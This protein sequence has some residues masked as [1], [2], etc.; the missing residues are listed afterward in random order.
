MFVSLLSKMIFLLGLILIGYIL[1]KAKLMPKDSAR[2]ISRLETLILMP[3]LVIGTLMK[4]CT[5]DNLVR[6]WPLLLF[7]SCLL[8]IL[9]PISLVLGKV[10][11]KEKHLQNIAIYGLVFSNFGFMGN[12][13][14]KSVFEEIFFFS[15]C[16]PFSMYEQSGTGELLLS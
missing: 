5:I 4:N 8:I 6:V 10:I 1:A 16:F 2:I 14:V 13:V 12:A 7:S 11:F 9:I 15:F 3:C